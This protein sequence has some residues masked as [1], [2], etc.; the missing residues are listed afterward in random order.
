MIQEELT[1]KIRGAIFDVLK[2]FGPGLFEGVYEK[3]L[4]VELKS[5]GL[6]VIA[7]MP[8]AVSYKGEDLNLGFKLDLLVENEIIIE[9]KSIQALQDVHKKQLLTYLRLA[10]KKVGLLVNFNSAHL[11]DGLSLIRIVN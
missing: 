6:R 7:Q 2:E 4:V 10:H 11:Q 5:V 3:A 1:Y 8:V 9:V